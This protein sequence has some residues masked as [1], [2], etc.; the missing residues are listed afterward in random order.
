MNFTEDTLIHY[1]IKRRSGRYP[2]G[3]GEHPYQSEKSPPHQAT[4]KAKKEKA[5]KDPVKMKRAEMIKSKNLHNMSPEDLQKMINRL[6]QEKELKNL[7]EADIAPGKKVIKEVLADVGKQTA[8]EVITGS[9]RYGINL[10]LQDEKNRKF[11]SVDLARAIYPSLNKKE[12]K[13]KKDD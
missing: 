8:K 10:A 7:V 2:W 9:V 3:S 5:P 13:K 1:G 4:R 11:N 6:K 12:E